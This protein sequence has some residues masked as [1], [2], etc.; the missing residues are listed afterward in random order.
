MFCYI[1]LLTRIQADKLWLNQ[2]DKTWLLVF[3]IVVMI[4]RIITPLKMQYIQDA[5]HREFLHAL[6]YTLW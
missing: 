3:M 5:I 6:L 4:T 1:G 2:V